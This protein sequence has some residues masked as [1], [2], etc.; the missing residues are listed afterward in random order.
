MADNIRSVEYY[1]ASVKDQAG[2]GHRVL[3]ALS[4]EGVDLRAFCGFPTGEGKAQ[5]DFVPT[6]SKKFLAAAEK[7][8]LR[9]R[10]PKQAFLISGDDRV[11]AVAS[12]LGKLASA[13]I[14]ITAAQAVSS[15]DG[16]FGMLLWVK[17]ARHAQAA[18]AL[19]I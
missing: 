16:R 2:E 5:L 7:L 10:K 11:G 8:K 15:G 9:V 4:D 13:K 19:G 6:D 14:P 18:R 3:S 1:A 12:A 17:P